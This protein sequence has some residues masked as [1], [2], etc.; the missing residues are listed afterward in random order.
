M[1]LIDVQLTRSLKQTLKRRDSKSWK[2]IVLSILSNTSKKLET[3]NCYNIH[4]IATLRKK[5][6]VDFGCFDIKKIFQ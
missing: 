3:N 6:G 1:P 4:S 2:K 5:Y